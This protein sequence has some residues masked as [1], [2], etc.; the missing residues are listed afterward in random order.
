MY[1]TTPD[2]FPDLHSTS[3]QAIDV[4]VV[5]MQGLPYRANEEDIV[6]DVRTRWR[7]GVRE[8]CEV[9]VCDGGGC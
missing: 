9:V 5:R 8:R 3:I 6:R 2:D 1:E 4:R 7:E